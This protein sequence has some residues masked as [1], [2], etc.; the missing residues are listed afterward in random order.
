VSATN[1]LLSQMRYDPLGATIK[2]GRDALGEG[3]DLGDSQGRGSF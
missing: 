2:F 3:S 1:K